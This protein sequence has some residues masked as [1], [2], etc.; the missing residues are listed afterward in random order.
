MPDYTDRKAHFGMGPCIRIR[1]YMTNETASKVCLDQT[2]QLFTPN[3][4]VMHPH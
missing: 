3:I 2:E 4:R 1:H